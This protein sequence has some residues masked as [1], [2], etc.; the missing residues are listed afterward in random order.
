MID[1]RLKEYIDLVE[2]DPREF[3]VEV[4]GA[5][6]SKSFGLT[7]RYFACDDANTFCIPVTQSYDVRFAADPDG[8]TVMARSGRGGRRRP[9]GSRP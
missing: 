6:E 3:L 4:E 5:T 1:A 9:G 2:A 7:V 8:G